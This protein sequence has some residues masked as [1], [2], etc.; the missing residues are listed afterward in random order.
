MSIR[1]PLSDI[2]RIW[3]QDNKLW[4]RELEKAEKY[5]LKRIP[6]PCSLHRG[7]GHPYSLEEVERHLLRHGRAP[8][9]RVWH[10]PTEPDS[11]DDE[12]ESDFTHKM[13][14]NASNEQGFDSGLQM[15]GLLSDM[16]QQIQDFTEQEEQLND[17]AMQA[18][19]TVDEITRIN[20][21]SNEVMGN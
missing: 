11:S 9:C 7:K 3:L 8:E 1:F 17:I 14:S 5:S 4:T 19:E 21:D 18:M 2:R 10:G 13:M 15:R 16:F 20:H 12:W 6:C